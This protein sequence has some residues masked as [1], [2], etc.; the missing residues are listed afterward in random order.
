MVR[1]GVVGVNG[2]CLTCGEDF[3]GDDSGAVLKEGREHAR[4]NKH[5]VDVEVTTAYRYD[6]EEEK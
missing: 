5:N 2:I 6:F 4:K 3:S 1:L